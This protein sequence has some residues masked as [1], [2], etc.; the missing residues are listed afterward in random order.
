LAFLS[1]LYLARAGGVAASA[2]LLCPY[3]PAMRIPV[4]GRLTD[5]ACGER[6]RARP[7]ATSRRIGSLP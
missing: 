1:P 4:R 6:P 5:P 3:E 2:E 7:S